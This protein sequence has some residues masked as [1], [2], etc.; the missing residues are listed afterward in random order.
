[1]HFILIFK[2]G[3]EWKSPNIFSKNPGWA[4]EENGLS[5]GIRE[6]RIP[7]NKDKAII[8]QG[9][10]KYNFFVEATQNLGGKG[11]ATIQAF[12]FCGAKKGKVLLY[13]VNP[14]KREITKIYY[15][16]G[17]EYGG[18]PTRGWRQGLFDQKAKEGVCSI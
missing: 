9:F 1:M 2:N 10:E 11:G 17:K 8:L 13:R 16:D 4:S 18:S 15:E 3:M 5:G 14:L 12:C 7:I 6:M